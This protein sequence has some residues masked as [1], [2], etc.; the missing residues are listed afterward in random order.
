MSAPSA[1]LRTR[2]RIGAYVIWDH[3]VRPTAVDAND[4]PW[5]VESLSAPWLTAVLSRGIQG[6]TVE[7]FELGIGHEG[8]SVRRQVRVR[9]NETGKA[10]F[11][12]SCLR[13][14]MHAST[15]ERGRSI[16]TAR[17]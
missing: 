12:S 17:C 2:A 11:Q 3:L 9:W 14:A 10:A 5:S 16:S 13:T 6:A 15:C 1:V 4:V 8:S 7:A